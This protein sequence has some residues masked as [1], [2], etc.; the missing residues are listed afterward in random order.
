[1]KAK[2]W[3]VRG[4]VPAPLTPAQ[5]EE[6]I[7][8]AV[9][10]FSKDEKAPHAMWKSCMI[11]EDQKSMV[12]SWLK[13][14]SEFHQC[15]TYGGN[16]TCVEVR[17]GEYL[18]IIDMGT[19]IRPLG[20]SLLSQM[21]LEA[22]ILMTH[23][24]WD[25]IQGLPFFIPMYVPGNKL[26]FYGGED[27]QKNLEEVL[28]GQMDPPLFPVDFRQVQRT[29]A[30]MKFEGIYDGFEKCN[31]GVWDPPEPGWGI[32]GTP[33]IKCRKLNHPNETYGWRIKHGGKVFVFATDTE[34][35]PVK[36][37]ALLELAKDADVLCVDAQYTE[38][39]YEGT[40]S[41]NS[42][43]G[44]G[45]GTPNFAASVAKEAGAK[46]LILVHHDP[47]SPDKDIYDIEQTAKRIFPA[48][49][50]AYEG[51]ELEI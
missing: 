7:C 48:S 15:S 38:K 8:N 18:I 4:S 30:K 35:Y 49:Y 17:C 45:H 39:Q 9:L 24:H 2:F 32:P 6:K 41:K 12:S 40:S 46:K 20:Q 33:N 28:N 10:K 36:H 23:I 42:K 27:W 51:M 37:H 14:N 26:C 22:T 3:G 34:P 47:A 44:W 50:A 5:I 11:T 29:G 21:P 25:H 16:T 31:V 19:G 43:V 13:N 1:M